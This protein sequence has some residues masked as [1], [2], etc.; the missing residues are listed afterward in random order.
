[1]ECRQAPREYP[2]SGQIVA[3]DRESRQL[4]VKHEDIPGLMPGMVMSFDVEDQGEIDRRTVG[5][6]I[7]ATLVVR[8]NGS[9]LRNVKVVGSA[10][11]DAAVARAAG[12]TL[13]EPGDLVPEGEFT[14]QEGRARHLSQWRGRGVLLTFIY[15]RCPLPDFCPRIERNLLQIQHATD[16][17]LRRRVALLAVSFDPAYDTPAVLRKHAAAIGADPA[18][19]S[20]L[21]GDPAGIERFA[22]QFGVT[23]IRNAADER[24]ITHNLRTVILGADGKVRQVVTGSDWDPNEVLL[25]LRHAS[26]VA[27]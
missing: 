4:T 25:S 24:D 19:W 15:T 6:L 21:T 20:F 3:V 5:E 17:D 27:Q 7:T 14:D 26:A 9:A 10:P 16:A 23:I 22:A 18:L 8:D 2:L 13:L 11:V 12:A 1:M